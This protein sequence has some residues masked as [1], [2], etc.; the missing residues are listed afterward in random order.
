VDDQTILSE[1]LLGRDFMKGMDI[2]FGKN[3]IMMNSKHETGI[4]DNFMTDLGLIEYEFRNYVELNVGEEVSFVDKCKLKEVYDKYYTKALKPKV[5]EID[6][7][8][9][10]TLK[11]NMPFNYLP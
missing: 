6:Y 8:A 2:W 9:S 7:E 10:I 4:I 3:D 5:S 1:C 11:D